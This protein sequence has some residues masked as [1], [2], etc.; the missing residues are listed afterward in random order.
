MISELSLEIWDTWSPQPHIISKGPDTGGSEN[1]A[2]W[3]EAWVLS[4]S[5]ARSVRTVEK[6]ES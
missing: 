5:A 6:P 4:L 1:C 2:M 3:F